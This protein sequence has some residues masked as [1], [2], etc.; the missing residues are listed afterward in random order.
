MNTALANGHL[1]RAGIDFDRIGR[2]VV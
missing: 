2:R 1:V